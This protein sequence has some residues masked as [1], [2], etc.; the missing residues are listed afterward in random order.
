MIVDDYGNLILIEGPRACLKGR[1]DPDPRAAHPD[2]RLVARVGP[3]GEERWECPHCGMAWIFW[4]TEGQ[5][6][7]RRGEER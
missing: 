2:A 1:P 3:C 7:G 6:Q 4:D 5:G